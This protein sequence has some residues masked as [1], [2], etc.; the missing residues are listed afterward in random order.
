MVPIADW[1]HATMLPAEPSSAKLARDFV[2]LHLVAHRLQ[3]LVDDVRLVVSEL[4]TNAVSHAHTPFVVTLSSASGTVRLAIQDGSAAAAVRS[5]PDL[6]GLGGRGLMIVD[7]LSQE[8]GTSTDA[9]GY[10]SVWA[11]FPSG[12]SRN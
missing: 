5:A 8:W 7:L 2:C 11:S 10:K 12:S 9:Q 6:L 4:A 1:S 3:H